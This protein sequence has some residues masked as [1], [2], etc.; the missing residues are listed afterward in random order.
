MIKKLEIEKRV[1]PYPYKGAMTISNDAEFMS[2]EF[3]ET[4]Y[5][6]LNSNK[7]TIFGDGLGLQVT[8]SL[9]FYSNK[10]YNLSY[11]NGIE[12]NSPKN[13]YAQ[14]LC[15]YLK[16]GW[17]DTNHA[18]GDFDGIGG[19]QRAHAI[20]VL[21]E[22]NEKQIQ[23]PCFTNHGDT[24][25][26]QNIGTDASYHQGD[27]PDSRAYHADLLHQLGTRYIWTDSAIF[28]RKSKRF[29]RISHLTIKPVI[30]KRRLQDGQEFLVFNRFRSTGANA[31]N[32][33]SLGYQIEQVNLEELYRKRGIIVLYQHLGVLGR[34]SGKCIPATIEAVR[35]RPEVFLAP[36]YRLAREVHEGRLWLPALHVL[37]RY[38]EML[39]FTGLVRREDNAVEVVIER[40]IPDP[41]EYF[42]GL[43][44]Y[45]DT[46][47]SVS[48]IYCGRQIPIVYNG[49]DETGRYSVTVPIRKKEDIW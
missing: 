3:F 36:W 31:P 18:Y 17:I 49:P 29:L 4:F 1:L 27:R 22:M 13:G 38:C 15:E 19:F 45:I 12:V 42:Q 25:N 14:R 44:F 23:I 9:F 37:L 20:R 35:S 40:V 47:D 32:L 34:N 10:P 43:T 7:K 33:S 41:E 5:S 28:A 16:A 30:V 46:R 11:F 8:S 2:F 21:E 6:F 48:L 24:F 26:I 39:L